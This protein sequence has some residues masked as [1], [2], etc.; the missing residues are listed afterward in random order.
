V[1]RR[2]PRQV[3]VAPVGSWAE[4]APIEA[5]N[6]CARAG[7]SSSE[8]SRRCGDAAREP[9]QGGTR[10][11]PLRCAK[12]TAR[13]KASAYATFRQRDTRWTS[14]AGDGRDD[15]L[16]SPPEDEVLPRGSLVVGQPS[17]ATPVNHMYGHSDVSA[18]RRVRLEVRGDDPELAS[19]LRI[20]E[21]ESR[22]GRAELGANR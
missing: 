3:R 9:D 21:R 4:F 22:G 7:E 5:A 19:D 8:L 6:V 20:E 18:T 15:L 12:D 14:R 2:P 17:S 10:T 11:R 1:P 16:L 13:C